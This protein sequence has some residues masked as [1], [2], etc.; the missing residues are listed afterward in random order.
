VLRATGA[1]G[2][3]ID[4]Y[5]LQ[6]HHLRTEGEEHATQGRWGAQEVSIDRLEIV[7]PDGSALDRLRTGDPVTFRFH[8]SAAA[9]VP[10]P[11]FTLAIHAL[12][13]LVVTNPSTRDTDVV[14]DLVEGEG[15]VDLVVDSLPLL[16]G[17]YDLSGEVT[18]H[19]GLHVHDHRH[20]LIRFDVE[21][22]RPRESGGLVTLRGR[23]EISS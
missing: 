1:A 5:L 14:G 2:D 11:V 9:P 10:K 15:H 16:P 7:G 23:W 22:G 13:G 19:A 20:R 3:V 12:D 18:D 17:T 4:E 21:S 6:V 8:W